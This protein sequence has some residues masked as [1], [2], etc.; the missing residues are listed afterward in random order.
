MT[1]ATSVTPAPDALA[2]VLADAPFARLVATDD[3]DALAAAALLARALRAVGTPFQVRVSRDPVPDARD[4]A[5]AVAV[6]ADRGPHAIPG[7]RRPASADAFAIARALGDDDPDPVVAL[8]GVVAA[9]SVPGTDG[10]GDALAAAEGDDRVRRRPGVALPTADVADGLA[11]STLVRTPYSGDGEAARAALAELGLPADIDDDAHRRL[12]SLVAVDVADADGASARAASAVER[13]LR[14]YATVGDAAP[15]ETVG[16]YA[17]VLDALAREAPGTGV[18]LALDAD[19]DTELRTA[20]LD[21][22]RTH[23]LAAHR[24][25]DAATAARYDGC[26]VARVDLAGDDT[27]GG[28]GAAPDAA[29]VLPTVARLARDFRSPE[30]VAVAVDEAA[31]LLAAAAINGSRAAD[32]A[33]PEPIG[34]GDACRSAAGDVG[35][36][37]WGTAERGGIAVAESEIDGDI[38]GALAALREAL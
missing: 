2:G 15:F 31:G 13:A 5:V 12:A 24:A 27:G 7:T 38:T 17:D 14:P 1:E 3:G 11:A 30:P 25:L 9:G 4:D 19:P 10:S 6:G 23:G 18:A 33:P 32:D 22:W 20:T 34:I 29:A 35:G 37:G 36:D 28:D 26:F 16:G 8:A 21:A